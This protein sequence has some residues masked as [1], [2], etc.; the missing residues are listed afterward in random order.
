MQFAGLYFG[1]LKT[2]LAGQ[3]A[4]GRWRALLDRHNQAAIARIQFALAGVNAHI[5][6]DL[7]IALVATST[8][9][10]T[11]PS[12]STKQYADYTALN[13]TLDG[14]VDVAKRE[15]HLRLLGDALPPLSH[16]E[17]SVAAF[18]VSAAREGAWN[19]AEILWALRNFP[20]LRDRTVANIDGL[21]TLAGKGILAPVPI[22]AAVTT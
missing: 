7:P 11:V 8:L 14:L 5:N 10:G 21:T 16:V 15:L 6:H 2:H 22:A 3:R 19:S 9:M 4:A 1:A 18:S 17:D 20:M 13:T 12:H